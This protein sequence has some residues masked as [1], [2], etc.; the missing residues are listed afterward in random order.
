MRRGLKASRKMG[1]R[2][3]KDQ[4]ARVIAGEGCQKGWLEDASTNIVK[5]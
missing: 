1:A 3:G 4:G 5:P 2:M